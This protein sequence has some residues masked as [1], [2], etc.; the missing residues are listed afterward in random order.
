MN[1]LGFSDCWGGCVGLSSF[2]LGGVAFRVLSWNAFKAGASYVW[3]LSWNYL[4]FRRYINFIIIYLVR[5]VSIMIGHPVNLIRIGSNLYIRP[6][7]NSPSLT[8]SDTSIHRDITPYYVCVTR[9]SRISRTGGKSPTE[10]MCHSIAIKSHVGFPVACIAFSLNGHFRFVCF[11]FIG[12]YVIKFHSWSSR[13]GSELKFS[14]CMFELRVSLS[15]GCTYLRGSFW[16]FGD[17]SNC[18][19]NWKIVLLGPW[20]F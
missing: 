7:T 2:E 3:F 15:F 8:I 4:I 19:C 17:V 16:K 5:S 1:I 11:L 6:P 12:L 13:G 9:F 10:K 14:S 20:R 18:K